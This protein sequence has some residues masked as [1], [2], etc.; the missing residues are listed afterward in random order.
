MPD[1]MR[2]HGR[3]GARFLIHAAGGVQIHQVR[4]QALERAAL[5]PRGHQPERQSEE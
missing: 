1:L 2:V 4:D 5:P 3:A